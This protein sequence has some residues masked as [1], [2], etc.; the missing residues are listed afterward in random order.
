M[1]DDVSDIAAYYNDDPTRE[2]G[3]L[4]R[5]QL[6]YDLTWRYLTQYLPSPASI[7]E[8]GA[9]TGRYTLE[10]ARRGYSITAVDMSAILL[11]ECKKNLVEAGL[12]NQVRFVVADARDLA[13][14]TEKEFDAVL[15]MG[16]LYHLIEEADRKLALKQALNRVRKG[17]IL[18]S[19]F[20]SRFGVLGDLM[21]DIPDWI[22]DQANAHSLLENG[23]RP[24]EYPR[25]GFRGY[26]T[27]VSEIAPLHESI[28]FETITVAGV[29]PAISADDESYN[30]LAGK[31]RKLWLD[32][33]FEVSTE[34]SI[35]G[36]SRHLLYIGRKK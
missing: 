31:Q 7:L 34:K 3:R 14:V 9:A 20:I 4:E 28:G 8:V 26:F 13:Q 2:H 5:H 36:A 6:E 17:G 30:R 29:E 10:L 11:E 12:E 22:E 21:R 16:P 25:G 1:S 15:F 27:L 19:S 23:K 35:I 18:F 32:L 33:L 24:D